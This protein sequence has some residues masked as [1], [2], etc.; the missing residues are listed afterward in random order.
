MTSRRSLWTF[1]PVAMMAA[2]GCLATQG[3][4]R[5]LQD[6]LRASRIQLA[7]NDSA[8]L[9]AEDARQREIAALAGSIDR[10]NDSVRV[11][12]TRLA[13]FQG[14]ATGQFDAMSQQV[15]KIENLLGQ[16]TRD[17]QDQMRALAVLR[18]QGMSGATAPAPPASGSTTSAPTVAADTSRGSGAPGPATMFSSAVDEFR[19]GSY[20]TA[21]SGFEDLIKMYPDYAQNARAQVYIGDA[22]KADG[23][24]AAADSVYQL[25]E[26]KYSTSPDAAGA[27]WRRGRML[28][29]SNDPNKKREARIVLNRLITKFPQSDEAELAKALLNPSE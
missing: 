21:R 17:I 11:L 16:N 12:T 14:A 1:A 3:N 22:F 15:I 10:L 28:W 9:R 29:D 8:I 26:T 6:E 20:R 19:K 13:L 4:V 18:E 23:N 24:T 7:Q 2:T 5:V 25:V 27:L